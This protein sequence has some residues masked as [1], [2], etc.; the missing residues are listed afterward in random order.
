MTRWIVPICPSQNTAHTISNIPVT[1][2]WPRSHIIMMLT[3]ITTQFRFSIFGKH[4]GH[5]LNNILIFFTICF[6]FIWHWFPSQWPAGKVVI[7]V[8]GVTTMLIQRNRGSKLWAVFYS[9]S[10]SNH[11]TTEESTH[12]LGVLQLYFHNS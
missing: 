11:N 6:L 9:T 2:F 5:I 8:S 1:E 12:S 10:T 3:M 4:L 7:V